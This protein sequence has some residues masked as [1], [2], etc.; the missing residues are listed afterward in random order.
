MNT[1]STRRHVRLHHGEAF[2][3]KR[4]ERLRRTAENAYRTHLNKSW[5]LRNWGH[6]FGVVLSA[7]LCGVGVFIVYCSFLTGPIPAEWRAASITFLMSSLAAFLLAPV[8]LGIA[9][10]WLTDRARA[11]FATSGQ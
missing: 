2:R 10:E 8:F 5:L 1:L 7:P 9:H 4:V 3:Q 11:T 6:I